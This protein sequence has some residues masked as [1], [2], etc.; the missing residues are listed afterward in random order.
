MS[1]NIA[2]AKAVAKCTNVTID[3]KSYEGFDLYKALEEISYCL[4]KIRRMTQDML[5]TS[6]PYVLSYG[7]AR[8]AGLLPAPAS[9]LGHEVYTRSSILL[10]NVVTIE[11]A[12]D[13]STSIRIRLSPPNDQSRFPQGG[14]TASPFP[15]DKQSVLLSAPATILGGGPRCRYVAFGGLGCAFLR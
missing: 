1:D 13:N 14:A 7:K 11:A 5:D 10:D 3:G 9:T 4:S 6:D 2:T 8:R 15:W 12:F